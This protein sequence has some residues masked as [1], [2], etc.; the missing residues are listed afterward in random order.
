MTALPRPTV[1]SKAPREQREAD[2]VST[3]AE[4]SD[5]DLNSEIDM[6]DRPEKKKPKKV[7]QTTLK[8]KLS[9]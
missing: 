8:N 3:A 9:V 7:V 5:G 6:S 1:G 2:D 4:A